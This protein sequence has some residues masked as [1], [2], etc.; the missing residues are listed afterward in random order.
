MKL[1]R[2]GLV[3]TIN[4]HNNALNAMRFIASL[5]V[6]IAHAFT[7]SQGPKCI[8]IISQLTNERVG[9]GALAVLILFFSS[10]LLVSKSILTRKNNKQYI[11]NR[12]LRIFPSL[13]FI[14]LLTVFV[15]GPI[16]TNY[17]L[18]AYFT[19]VDTYKYLLNMFLIP[20]HSL[21]GVFEGNIFS[22]TVNGSLWTLPVEFLC[23][24]LLLL[25]FN[26]KILNKKVVNIFFPVALISF[27]VINYGSIESLN[28]IRGYI[29]PMYMFYLGV[30]AYMNKDKIVLNTKY[31]LVGL[32]LL[33]I[34]TYMGYVDAAMFLIFPYVF[35]TFIYYT[36]ECG[37]KVGSLGI[38][39][40]GIYLCGFPIQQMLVSFYGG[41]MSPYINI[42][43]S[44]P[45][46][47]I[48]GYLIYYITERPLHKKSS[49][50]I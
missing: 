25:V 13:I 38:F 43:V 48:T 17:S 18:V 47:I 50:R 16:M 9:T 5:M 3:D 8:D 21:P 41:K 4:K 34:I 24:M 31:A 46:A 7:L 23:Y 37:V 44:V 45:M 32:L 6:I 15:I 29:Y 26:M 10:G 11:K 20:V 27:L 35:L 42:L 39:S 1:G 33:C 12:F 19:S 36:F 2:V 40:Y 49:R 14:V 22:N 30:V 28:S